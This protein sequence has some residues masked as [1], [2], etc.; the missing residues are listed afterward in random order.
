[1]KY[2]IL[3]AIL[4]IFSS[5]YSFANCP[6]KPLK[7]KFVSYDKEKN[8]ILVKVS[9]KDETLGLAEKVEFIDFNDL[10][11]LK[12]GS[13]INLLGMN[14]SNKLVNKIVLLKEPKS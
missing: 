3:S 10:D 7:C 9:K 13:K 2:L 11:K 8:T 12:S 1:M 6:G 4:F 5:I 14:C